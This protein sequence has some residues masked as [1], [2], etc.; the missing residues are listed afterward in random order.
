MHLDSLIDLAS[1]SRH[2]AGRWR[3][4]LRHPRLG[5]EIQE[6]FPSLT[7]AE[8]NMAANMAWAGLSQDEREG[9]ANAEAS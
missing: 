3:D 1:V 9:G 2:L 6:A 8:F 4:G 7:L 5:R